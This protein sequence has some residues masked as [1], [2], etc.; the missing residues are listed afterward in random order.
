[1]EHL[2]VDAQI[3]PEGR[4]EVLSKMEVAKLL[5]TSHDGLYNVFRNCSLAY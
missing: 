5:D 3:S 4:L 1:M 2:V